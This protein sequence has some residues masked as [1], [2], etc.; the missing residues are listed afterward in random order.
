[1]RSDK[2]VPSTNKV[3]E[4]NRRHYKYRSNTCLNCGQPLD[5][6]D[7]YCAYCSQLNS[8]KQL[9]LK[10]FFSEFFNSIV[11][12]DS[13][14]RYTVS[15]L[16]F[17]PGR[18]TKNYS[19]GQRLKYAN[20]FRFFLSVSIIYFLL[21]SLITTVWGDDT[22]KYEVSNN[23]SPIEFSWNNY[24][25]DGD[26]NEVE[27][28]T[29]K[30]SIGAANLEIAKTKIANTPGL[31]GL[32]SIITSEIEKQKIKDSIEKKEPT[33]YYSEEE[34]DTMSWGNNVGERLILYKE[35]YDKSSIKDPTVA[36]DSLRHHNTRYHRWL[37]SRSV[38][39]QKIV[40]DPKA[41]AFYMLQKA[42]FFIFFFTPFYALFFWILYSKKK[43][44]YMEH[45]V[46]IFHLFSFLFIGM[47]IALI[48]DTIFSTPVFK[49][50][51]FGLIGPLYFYKALRNFYK[52]SRFVT[53]FKF[54]FLNIVF[55]ISASVAAGIFF[56]IT[57]AVF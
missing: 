47:F 4:N 53:I 11:S 6:T 1:M 20:P 27:T 40:E 39:S 56:V 50:I 51:L 13:R 19:N 26:N 33:T 25:D 43:F 38:A 37:Y 3:S 29:E 44:S 57:A 10:D 28:D 32:D 2:Q 15:D 8:T 45:M 55:W 22:I 54:V 34:L 36:L 49:G 31:K 18:V 5:L 35:F 30:D 23:K 14:L 12:Y 21:N 9:S 42:P 24:N 48:P 16:L 46:F 52:Q 7:V 41:Y 17:R